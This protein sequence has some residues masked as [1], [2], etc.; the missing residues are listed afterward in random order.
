M[1]SIF[2]LKN[3][4]KFN[5]FT[6]KCYSYR[7]SNRNASFP[8][9]F[10]FICCFR[11]LKLSSDVSIGLHH[12]LWA[13]MEWLVG[14]K[15]RQNEPVL[16]LNLVDNSPLIPPKYHR[17]NRGHQKSPFFSGMCFRINCIRLPGYPFWFLIL[18]NNKNTALVTLLN[19]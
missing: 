18:V 4:G 2:V 15:G 16:N 6:C 5:F 14:K 9:L 19:R 3:Y 13:A 17:T 7:I 10:S 1:V 12:P 11:L 8:I